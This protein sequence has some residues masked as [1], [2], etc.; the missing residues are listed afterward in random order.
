MDLSRSDAFVFF[1]ATGDLARKQIWP[2]LAALVKAGRLD[3]PIVAVGRKDIGTEAIR[4]R[5]RES[6]EASGPFDGPAFEKLSS[7]LSY[8]AVDY[9]A[10]GTF[11]G[12]KEAVA[13]ARHPLSYVALPPD[14]FEKV[15]AN[16]AQAGLAKGGRLVVEKPFGHDGPSARALSEALHA[17]FP[18][19]AIF[20]IDHYLGKEQV[21]NIVYFRA[22]NPLFEASWNRDHVACVEI[23]MAETFGVKGRAEL[24]DGVGAIRDVVQNH[25]LEVVACIAMDLP[26]ER[27]HAAL[28]EARTRLLARI[29]ALDPADVV[30]GQVRGYR[31]EKGVRKDSTTE[32]FAALRLRIDAP[33]WKDV[34]VFVRAGKSLAVTATEATVRW[35]GVGHPVLEDGYAPAPNAL[36]FRLGPDNLIALAANVKSPGEPIAGASSELVLRRSADGAMKPY[37]RLLGDAIDGD[38]AMYARR[39]AVEESWRVVDGALKAETKLHPYDEGSWGPEEARRVAP[40]GGWTNPVK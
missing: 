37:E 11:A 7:R 16:L 30:R 23:T 5:A 22:S 21:E 12:I 10:P 20:R 34:P 9:D 2:A 25:L 17:A 6:L 19:E 31:D 15:A 8:V 27:G 18:E 29:E 14:V 3:M 35:R 26:A 33:R 40:E 28:R 13:S 39:A 36:R 38:A 1:G 32:T 4:A 24:Y